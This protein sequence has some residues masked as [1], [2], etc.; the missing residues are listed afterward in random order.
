MAD[1]ARAGRV[2]LVAIVVLAGRAETAPDDWAEGSPDGQDGATRDDYNRAGRLAWHH[3]LG[4]WRDAE[5]AEQGADPYAIARI[6]DDDRT[7]P[8]EWDVTA[9]VRQWVSGAQPQQGFFLRALKGTFRF[10]S[11]EAAD[12]ALRPSLVISTAGENVAMAPEADTYLDRSTYRSLGR[13]EVL[14]AGHVLLRFPIGR[15]PAGTKIERATLRLHTF[16]QYGDG[17]VAVFRCRQGHSLPPCEPRPGLAAG[18]PDDAKI[19]EDP[20]V[21]FASDFESAS[22]REEWTFAQGTIEPVDVDPARRFEPLSGRALR[23]RIPRGENGA[24]SAGFAFRKEIGEEP[25]EIYFRYYLRLGDDWDQTVDGGKMPG[26]SGT[27]GVAGWGG[28]RSNGENGWSARGA[29]ARSIPEGN[30]LAGTHPIGTYCY[31]ADQPGTYGEI[32]LW[33]EGYRGFLEKNRWFC[34]EQFVRLNEPGEKDGILRAWV[35]GRLA[36]EKTDIRFRKV[37]RLRIEQVWMN[38]YHG[39]TATSPRDQHLFIDKVVIARAYIGPRQD[40]RRGSR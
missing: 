11:R 36:F 31:H 21:V 28:R 1:V 2:L 27:Y 14:V 4:D 15:I 6:D 12:E 3:L 37:P 33:Q 23:V 32:W 30:P 25:E 17:E 24:M 20:A 38:V 7:K 16:A 26:V 29:F 40:P 13:A 10:H 39:G 22:W 34:I 18:Y 8:V 19:G 9:L 35:D 5:D